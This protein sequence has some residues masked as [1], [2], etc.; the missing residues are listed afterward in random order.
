VELGLNR[1]D[2]VS[3][4]PRTMS[5]S[6]SDGGMEPLASLVDERRTMNE[7]CGGGSEGDPVARRMALIAAGA[8]LLAAA[9]LIGLL[10]NAIAL[11][12]KET[13]AATGESVDDYVVFALK[14]VMGLHDRSA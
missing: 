7:P 1:D 14:Y 12:V 3:N 10:D 13:H 5:K 11:R 2:P 6:S 9:R 4:L 8:G